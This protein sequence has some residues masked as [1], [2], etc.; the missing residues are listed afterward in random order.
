MDGVRHTVD[1]VKREMVTLK[2]LGD[3]VS[4]K[5]A[6]LEAHREA[7]ERAL[8]QA[9]NLERAMKSIDNGVRQQIENE[10]VL[11]GLSDEVGQLRTLNEEVVERSRDMA[12][13][14]RQT[15][16]QASAIRHEMAAAQ[17]QMKNAVERF[18]FESKGLESVSQ[19][20]ADLRGTLSD[21]ENRYR[22]LR[23]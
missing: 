15:D 20:V 6:A 1:D 14:Q 22:G 2:S 11:H 5:T 16:E 18:D 4:Q 10:K 23:E 3:S 19:R 12:R 13:L 21:F 7:V 17:D 9:E 8:A